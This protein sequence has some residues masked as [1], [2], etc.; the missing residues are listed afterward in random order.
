MK[1][2]QLRSSQIITTFG[3]GAMVDLPETSVIIAGLDHWIYDQ[4]RIPVVDEPRLV[5]KLRRILDVPHLTLR[6]PPPAV[7]QGRGFSPTITAWRFPEYF[8]VQR[9]E[10]SARGHR[11]RRLVHLNALDG[12]KFRGPE[13]K[14]EGVV[15]VRF[16]RACRKGHVGDIDWREFVHGQPG[17]PRDLYLEERGTSGALDE[18][19]VRCDCGAERGLRQAPGRRVERPTASSSGAPATPTSRRGCR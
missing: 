17:C 10:V 15:P 9:A 3:P 6:Q 12:G 8:I 5:A 16:V 18:V 1:A 2:P 11:A 13:G 7:E 19:W 14:K 4:G